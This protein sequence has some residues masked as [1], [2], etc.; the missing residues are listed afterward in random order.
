MSL[1]PTRGGSRS[2]LGGSLKISHSIFF[3][4][5][6]LTDQYS[7]MLKWLSPVSGPFCPRAEFVISHLKI[8][9]INCKKTDN[10]E[11]G[12]FESFKILIACKKTH[13]Y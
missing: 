9:E 4:K 8:D 5:L 11:K 13:F 6:L 3:L 1:P 2:Q 10:L 12:Y 7:Y